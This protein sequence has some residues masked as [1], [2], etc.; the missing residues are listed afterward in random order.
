MTEPVPLWKQALFSAVIVAVAVAVW[1]F[2][3]KALALLR[4]GSPEPPATAEAQRTPR[5]TPVIV[6]PVREARD[7]VALEVIGTGRAARSI[8]L[9]SEASG[10]IEML[11][12]APNA[13]FIEGDVLMRL[14]DEEE[15][16]ALRLA[17]TR[18]EDAR[19]T[20]ERVRSLQGRGVAP[21]ARLDEVATA[22]AVAALE[23]ERAEQAL[24][25]RVLRAPFD[26]VS[27]LPSVEVGDWIDND[28]DI[29]AFDDRTH[30][31]VGFDVPEAVLSR[32]TEGLRVTARTPAV[33]GR[34]FEGTVVA[35][36][37]RVDPTSRTARVRV[38]IPN[39][40]DVLRP[41]SS[42]TIRLDLPGRMWPAVPE[43]ALQFARSG[44]HVWR[45]VDGEAERVDVR[46]VQRR[47]ERVL[48]DG[49]LE[50][51]DLVVVEG[52]QRLRP[53]RPVRVIGERTEGAA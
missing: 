13:R 38:T 21:D 14:E 6:A 53:A 20:L 46:L 32:V 50:P 10:K 23:R 44:L 42:F 19:R 35:V 12:L 5:G 3:D 37:S 22:E 34:T 15:R 40:D 43:L 52:T 26:G 2:P 29:A 45:V 33:P 51:G 4:L 9:R 28:V 18:L 16:L 49:P 47:A 1:Q 17:E 7:D 27:G 8:T 36:D 39:E 48:V 30:V 41:G 11:A 25:D 24:E 31:L